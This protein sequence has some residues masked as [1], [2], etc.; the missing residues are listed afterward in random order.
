MRKLREQLSYANVMSSI[1]VF[2]VLG[3]GAYAAATLPKNSVGSK[4]IKAN[5]V[6]SSKVKN[7]SLLSSDF[8]PGQL[9][10]G[11]PGPVGPAGPAGAA[12]AAGAKGEKGE[13][14]DKGDKGDAGP[15]L[16][17]LPS[18]KTLRGGWGFGYGPSATDRVTE[19]PI[20]FQVPLTISPTVEIVQAG[21]SPT[22]HC[23]GT[24]TDPTAAPG[25]LCIY[26]A[27]VNGGGP[28]GTYALADGSDDYRFGAEVYFFSNGDTIAEASGTWA[29]TAA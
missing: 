25:F 13:K 8:K 22:E 23:A 17:T 11:A 5:A 21:G 20:S 26:T 27:F 28:L 19:G 6:T 1:A 12:G 15:L 10:A 7:G 3:G 18:G 14:G 4:Q 29:V 9:V 24:F 2:V 16:T